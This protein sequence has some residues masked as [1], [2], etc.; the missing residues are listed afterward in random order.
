MPVN[1]VAGLKVADYRMSVSDVGH[2]FYFYARHIHIDKNDGI[3]RCSFRR[4]VF[5]L[6]NVDGKWRNYPEMKNISRTFTSKNS[7]HLIDQLSPRVAFRIIRNILWWCVLK[8]DMAE[9]CGNI[10]K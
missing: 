2:W 4:C 3:T 9:N 5:Y 10:R 7:K 6:Y 8:T 1:H